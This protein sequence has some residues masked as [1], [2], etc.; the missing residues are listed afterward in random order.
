MKLSKTLKVIVGIITAITTLW[1][2][3]LP[4]VWVLFLFVSLASLD[5]QSSQSFA[6]LFALFLIVPLMVVVSFVQIALPAFYWSHI[7]LNKSAPDA[8]RIMFGIGVFIL[9]WVALPLY[10]FVHVLPEKP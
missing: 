9:P 2:F 6:I 1:P 5:V 4:K 8:T 7:I 10:Y 3:V